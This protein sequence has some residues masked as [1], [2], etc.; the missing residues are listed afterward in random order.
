MKTES[1]T[2]KDLI[3]RADSFIARRAALAA[4]REKLIAEADLTLDIR[5]GE[6]LAAIDATLSLADQ[7]ENRIL[8]EANVWGSKMLQASV[9]IQVEHQNAEVAVRESILRR[10]PE[11]ARDGL[12]VVA[13][14][15]Y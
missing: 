8:S 13:T 7:Q 10:T 12:D 1:Q 2:L 5:I 11:D 14:R 4:E 3:N 15:A 6:R 9:N